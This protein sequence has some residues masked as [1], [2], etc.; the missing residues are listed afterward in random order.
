M[1]EVVSNNNPDFSN[2]IAKEL[3]LPPSGVAAAIRLLNEG[4]TVPFIARY[5]KEVTGGIDDQQLRELAQRLEFLQQLEA[6]RSDVLRLI[7]AQEQ[8]T[9]ELQKEIEA[10][11]SVTRLDD[12]Y[13]PYRPKRRTRASVAR[14]QG[15]VPLAD[16]LRL[17]DCNRE[18]FNILA[19]QLLDAE[20]GVLTEEDAVQ[21]ALDIMTEELSDD[22]RLRHSLRKQLLKAGYIHS[23]RK[24]LKKK[25]IKNAKDDSADVTERA[26]EKA[27]E[28]TD[29]TDRIERTYRA[30]KT[31]RYSVYDAYGDFSEPLRRTRGHRVLALNRGEKEGYL[32][33]GI[34]M[35]DQEAVKIIRGFLP[36]NT[37]MDSYLRQAAEDSWKRLIHPSLETEIRNELTA[38]AEEEAIIIFAKNLRDTLM[39]PPLRNHTVLALDPGYRNGCKLAVTD[40][41]GGVL[42]TS[43]IYPVKPQEDVTGSSRIL[44]EL[45]SRHAVGVLAL[46]NGTATRET[47]AF[48]RTYLQERGL[49]LPLVIVNEAGASVYSASEL[50]AEEFPDLD[51]SLRSAISLARRLQDPL[52]ELVKIEPAAIGV[53]QYQHDMNQKALSAGLAAVVED[54]VNEVGVDLNSASPSLLAYV[55]GITSSLAKNIHAYRE[56]NGSF[57]R[58]SGLLK[59][60][61]L[62]PKAYEQCAG[63]LRIVDGDEPLDATSVHP[64]SYE[65]ARLLLERLGIRHWTGTEEISQEAARIG[66]DKLASELE[67]GIPTLKDIVE[68]LEKPGRDSREDL[69]LTQRSSVVTDVNDLRVGMK[70]PGIVRNVAA[71]GVFVDIGVHQDGLVH[72][73][74]IADRFI[75]DPLNV[76]HAGE[77]VEVIVIGVDLERQRISLSMKPARLQ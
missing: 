75:S 45:I 54:C 14:E 39:A 24:T 67:L 3:S 55:S 27:T 51:V 48:V 41:N 69:D 77:R 42:A 64:E 10:A 32:K 12:L 60:S 65:A 73:S 50:A 13:R 1:T 53:G 16:L 6:K 59:V 29:T 49:S 56:T 4:N 33:V 5:R 43:H 31:D 63:F 34:G 38:R 25:T 58:R 61:R 36:A 8:L 26:A 40:P 23:K 46:G 17:E 71:F 11:D 15:L 35:E 62:G 7:D 57:K 28:R 19:R 66:I 18:S 47:E 21:G 20:K 74:E 52:A 22:P 9:P 30:D 68:A 2:R 70:L 72:I 76:V 44:D 37:E